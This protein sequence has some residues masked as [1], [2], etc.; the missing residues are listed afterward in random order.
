MDRVLASAVAHRRHPVAAPVSD[1]SLFRLI[2]RLV[3][4]GGNRVLDLGCGS[5]AWLLRLVEE[6]PGLRGVGLDTSAP[7]LAAAR[8]EAGRRGLTDRVEFVGGDA[9]AYAGRP[10]DVVLCVGATHAFGGLAGT[11]HA[12]RRHLRPGG[13][14]PLGDGFWETGPTRGRWPDWV[15]SRESCPTSPACWRWWRPRASSPAT[16]T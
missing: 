5:G 15:R 7:A 14:V 9:A 4:P 10:F 11:L 16:G 12:V 6:H 2:S 3:P 8:S 13:R 1:D